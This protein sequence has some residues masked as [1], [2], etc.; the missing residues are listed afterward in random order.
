MLCVCVNDKY[1]K[2][3]FS[4]NFRKNIPWSSSSWNI[5]IDCLNIHSFVCVCVCVDFMRQ[6]FIS[7]PQRRFCN[8]KKNQTDRT[9]SEKNNLGNR[10]T[11]RII[12]PVR[13]T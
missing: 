3:C 11:R 2:F 13:T 1:N 12:V 8:N 7:T 10:Y 5:P 6:E 9:Q 4:N